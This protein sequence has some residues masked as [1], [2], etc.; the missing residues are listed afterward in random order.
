[1]ARLGYTDEQIL[2]REAAEE[3]GVSYV[4]VRQIVAQAKRAVERHGPNGWPP[5]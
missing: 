1:M 5:S 3:L 2:L 4:R